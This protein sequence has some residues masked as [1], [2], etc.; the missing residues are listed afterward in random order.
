VTLQA[1]ALNLEKELRETNNPRIEEQID[2]I[3]ELANQMV[4]NLQSLKDHKLESAG[5]GNGADGR[6][7]KAGNGSIADIAQT[8]REHTAYSPPPIA[9]IKL[10]DQMVPTSNVAPHVVNANPRST[11][12]L[13]AIKKTSG[14][15]TITKVIPAIE[16]PKPEGIQQKKSN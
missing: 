1:A 3:L 7:G 2:K 15:P 14:S 16:K 6:N 13:P 9:Q 5:G 11:K 12:V 4:S 10:P 8:L